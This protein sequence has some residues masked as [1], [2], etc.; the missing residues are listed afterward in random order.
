L[1]QEADSLANEAS[2]IMAPHLSAL[3]CIAELLGL[4]SSDH[5]ETD[6]L[7]VFKSWSAKAMQKALHYRLQLL[8]TGR[9]YAFTWPSPDEIFDSRTMQ[10]DENGAEDS[11]GQ[12]TVLFTIFPGLK[13]KP[14]GSDEME[15]VTDAE[16]VVKVQRSEDRS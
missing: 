15:S 7:D 11:V 6:T 1:K 8:A 2:M 10:V 12:S 5:T 9:E 16:A 3:R 14:M 4:L 13:I